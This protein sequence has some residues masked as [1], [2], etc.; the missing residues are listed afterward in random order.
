MLRIIVRASILNDHKTPF[1]RRDPEN[2]VIYLQNDSLGR[3]GP[4]RFLKFRMIKS[5]AEPEDLPKKL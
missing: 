2:Y 4:S 1:L 5:I 3:R